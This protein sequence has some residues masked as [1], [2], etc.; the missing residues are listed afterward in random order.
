MTPDNK[1]K[2]LLQIVSQLDEGE[3]F[4]E[5]IDSNGDYFISNRGNVLSLCNN[6]PR[7]LKPFVCGDGYQYVTFYFRDYR[8]HRLVAKY[9]IENTDNKPIVHHKDGNKLNNDVNNLEWLTHSEHALKHHRR[10]NEII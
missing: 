2:T 3:C 1:T 7:F 9:F 5:I 4:K 6:K 10:H 8:I